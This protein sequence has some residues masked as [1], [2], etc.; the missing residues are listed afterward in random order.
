MWYGLPLVSYGVILV[1]TVNSI[2][3]VFQLAYIT[4]FIIY[5][6]AERKVCL[7]SCLSFLFFFLTH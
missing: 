7:I 2:G 3:A 4:L 1:A 6:D 5:A